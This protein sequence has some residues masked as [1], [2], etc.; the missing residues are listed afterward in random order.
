[1]KP[2]PQLISAAEL[3]R[4]V[5]DGGD[6][7]RINLALQAIAAHREVSIQDARD[8]GILAAPAGY[9]VRSYLYVPV[10]GAKP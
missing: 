9:A 10:T 6:R 5:Q 2:Q 7:E 4:R 1:M 8:A 3:A